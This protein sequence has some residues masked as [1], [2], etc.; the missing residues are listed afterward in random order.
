MEN[1]LLE[2]IRKK[3]TTLWYYVFYYEDNVGSMRC[4]K[5]DASR[6]AWQEAF[7]KKIGINIDRGWISF[8]F[9]SECVIFNDTTPLIF[10]DGRVEK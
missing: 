8:T 1:E 10:E 9:E 3:L 4:F 7:T 2:K 6:N 5:S